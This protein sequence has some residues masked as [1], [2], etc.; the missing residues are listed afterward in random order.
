MSNKYLDYPA[1]GCLQVWTADALLIKLKARTQPVL[2]RPL[3]RA[4]MRANDFVF[5]RKVT[6]FH[7][8]PPHRH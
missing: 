8:I 2:I 3:S 5:E 1:C 7:C 6:V 4:L